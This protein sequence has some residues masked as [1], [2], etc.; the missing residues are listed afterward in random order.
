MQMLVEVYIAQEM[1]CIDM[2]IDIIESSQGIVQRMLKTEQLFYDDES[3]EDVRIWCESMIEPD[4]VDVYTAFILS[5]YDYSLRRKLYH[6]KAYRSIENEKAYATDLLVRLGFGGADHRR[7]RLEL[8][9]T[10]KGSTFRS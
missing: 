5:L 10:L 6:R 3:Q 2:L 1:V 8:R 7:E 9:K 4:T